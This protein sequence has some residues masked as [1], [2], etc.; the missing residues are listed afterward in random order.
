MTMSLISPVIESNPV[1]SAMTSSLWK[2][3]SSWR[4]PPAS[5]RRIGFAL[6]ST[7]LMFDVGSIE[8]VVEVLLE[9]KAF[10]SERVGRDHWGEEFGFRWVVDARAHSFAPECVGFH[11]AVHVSDHVHVVI[12]EESEATLGKFIC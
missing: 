11:V 5:K 7:T 12:H 4:M 6:T 9:G 8:L 2:V 3:L 10:G 1:A